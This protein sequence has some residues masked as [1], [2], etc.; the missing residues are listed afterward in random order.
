MDKLA[1]PHLH[2]RAFLA[3]PGDV[4]DER[5]HVRKTLEE[6]PYDPLLR[7]KISLEVVAW[8]KPGAGT[9]MLAGMTPQEAIAQGLPKPSQ[10]DI[11]V[12]ILWSRMGTPLPPAYVKPDGSPY[13]SGTEWEYEDAMEGLRQHGKPV[14]L[15]Y[16]RTEKVLLDPDAADFDERAAQRKKVQTFFDRFKNPDGSLSGGINEYANLADFKERLAHDLRA[17]IN[18][19]LPGLAIPPTP[20]AATS[21]DYQAATGRYL[22]YVQDTHRYLSFRGMGFADRVPMR[23]PLVDLY[24]PLKARLELP[25]GETWSRGLKLA[26][27]HL[28]E[29]AMQEHSLRLGEPTPVL[30]LLRQQDG[31]VI[32]GDP[33]AGKTTF[34]KYLALQLAAGRHEVLGLGECLPILV[35]LSG[36]AN[37]LEKREIRLDEH[38]GAY[39]HELGSDEPI[40]AMLAEALKRG[41]ALVLLDGLDEVAEAGL[42]Q[43]VVDKVTHFYALHRK[44]GNKFVITSR[45]VGYRDIRPA[46]EGLAE[47]TLVDFDEDEI[48]DFVERWTRALEAQAQGESS[49]GAKDAKQERQGQLDAVRHNPGV[50]QLAANPLL[51]TILALMKRQE[52]SLPERRAELY[53]Q[54]VKTLLSSWN[55]ARG[56]GRPPSRDLDPVQTVKMLAPLALWMHEAN[57][58]VGLVKREDLRRELES[59]YRAR[60]DADP[61]SSARR[62]LAD[63]RGHAGLLL[64]RG[65]GEYGFIHLTFEEYLAAVAIALGHQGDA[66]AIAAELG[67]RVGQPAWHE[68]IRLTVG[69]VGLVQQMDRVAGEIVQILASRQPGPP[70]EAVV[71]AGEAVAD[72]CLAGVDADSR[73][74]VLEAL[75]ATLRQAEVPGKLRRSAGLLLGRLGWVP[76]DLDNFVPV[77]NE[78][79]FLYGENRQARDLPYEYWIAQYPVTNR[80]FAQFIEAGGYGRREFWTETGWRWMQDNEIRQPGYWGDLEFGNPLVP[81]VGVSWHEAVAYARWLD[82]VVAAEGLMLDGKRVEKPKGSILRLPAEWEWERAARGVDGREYP[83]GDGFKEARANAAD[84]IWNTIGGTTAVCAYLLGVSPAGAWDM[85]GNVW[86]WCLNQYSKANEC[87]LEGGESRVLRGGSWAY[88]PHG[89]RASYRYGGDPGVR[90]TDIGFRLVGASP[91]TGL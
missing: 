43:A 47:C 52:V 13:L 9:P 17:I 3:S 56:L 39:F 21:P 86:E 65:P 19:W 61:E 27:R 48:G 35:P 50:R 53:E 74:C 2:L 1:S 58:G 38:I 30:E 18:P 78:G 22:E 87:G 8:D 72:A 12:V 32:L 76:A 44:N 83:W 88:Y 28:E 85:A 80:Q 79:K 10:C 14:V 91:I 20:A 31:L 41:D 36:Y 37:A 77:R 23:L 46:A 51:L 49:Q 71:L 70:G 62:F 42:R 69:Y 63:V 7:G 40:Q 57:P 11:A 67:K 90:R 54:Y 24:V 29:D 55:R 59:L 25:H 5:A 6:L 89:A 15:V 66:K 84:D 16:R 75:Q 64:E 82:G 81:V 60:Q 4:S 45:I 26:G 33:G 73:A 34:L 68:I